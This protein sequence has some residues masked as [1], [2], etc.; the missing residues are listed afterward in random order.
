MAPWRSD[1]LGVASRSRR[2]VLVRALEVRMQRTAWRATVARDR[3][4]RA[5]TP[6]SRQQREARANS[7]SSRVS[8]DQREPTAMPEVAPPGTLAARRRCR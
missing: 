4:I 3:A 5:R 8:A 6:S 2:P 1:D 7:N